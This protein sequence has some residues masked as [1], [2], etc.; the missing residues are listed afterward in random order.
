MLQLLT[1]YARMTPSAEQDLLSSLDWVLQ[2]VFVAGSFIWE[3]EIAGG[4]DR[5][6]YWYLFGGLRR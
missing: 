5:R 2:A 3:A 6:V 4:F 1:P